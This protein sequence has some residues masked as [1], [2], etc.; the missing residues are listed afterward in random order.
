MF[1]SRTDVEMESMWEVAAYTARL[2]ADK[3]DL[4]V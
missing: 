1:F 4:Y 2:Y 3:S